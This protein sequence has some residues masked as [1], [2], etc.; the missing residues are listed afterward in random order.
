VND[1]AEF[2]DKSPDPGEETVRQH[3]YAEINEFGRL[4]FDRE[5]DRPAGQG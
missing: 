3:V 1:A 5:A 2:A 4:F